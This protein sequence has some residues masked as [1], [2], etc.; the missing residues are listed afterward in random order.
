[1]LPEIESRPLAG[2]SVQDWR[3]DGPR[4]VGAE[5]S[6]PPWPKDRL[7]GPMQEPSGMGQRVVVEG[8]PTPTWQGKEPDPAITTAQQRPLPRQ[9]PGERWRQQPGPHRYGISNGL[10]SICFSTDLFTLAML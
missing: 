5:G 7:P 3:G 9:V 8:E 10:T 2:P 1:M 6:Q 4:P